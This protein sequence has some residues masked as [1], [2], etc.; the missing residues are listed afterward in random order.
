M[1][2]KLR[3]WNKAFIQLDSI[4]SIRFASIHLSQTKN[5]NPKAAF[6]PRWQTCS[7]NA[8]TR[9]WSHQAGWQQTQQEQQE[10]EQEQE[11]EQNDN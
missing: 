10:P 9:R 1:L 2:S 5:L 7:Q 4:N 3:T 6:T 8:S 11:T